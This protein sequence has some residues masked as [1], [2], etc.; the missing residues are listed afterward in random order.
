MAT[1]QGYP[2]EAQSACWC[3]FCAASVVIRQQHRVNSEIPGGRQS[4][5]RQQNWE[6]AFSSA[7]SA[8]RYT[9]NK[10]CT[11]Y[12]GEQVAGVWTISV[13]N[14]GV[15]AYRPTPTTVRTIWRRQREAD[16]NIPLMVACVISPILREC[17][18]R[19]GLAKAEL[20]T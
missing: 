1:L 6:S 7:G 14:G 12:E 19:K 15:V 8:V 18:R 9:G 5:E 3:P 13:A 4:R 2:C 17:L 16:R 20:L 11:V 10:A